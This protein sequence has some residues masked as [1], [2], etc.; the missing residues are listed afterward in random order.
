MFNKEKE[1]INKNK[2]KSI[3]KEYN[4]W[5]IEQQASKRDLI[6]KDKLLT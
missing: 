6:K 2:K 3:T 1:I 5:K 4:D